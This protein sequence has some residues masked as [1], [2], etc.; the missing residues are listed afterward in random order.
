MY[1]VM[2]WYMFPYFK[3]TNNLLSFPD[4]LTPLMNY[5]HAFFYGQ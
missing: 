2:K 3:T 5:S 4:T 1:R